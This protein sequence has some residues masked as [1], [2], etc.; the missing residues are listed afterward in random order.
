[1]SVALRLPETG[2]LGVALSGGGDSMALLHMVAAER[3]VAAVTV[4]HGL[5]DVRAEIDLCARACARLGVPHRVLR[6]HWDG[7]GNLQAQARAARQHLI[8]AWAHDRGITHV[9]LGHTADDQ[10]ETVLM[11][12]ARGSG[13][14]GLAAMAPE[15]RAAGVSWLRPL[16]AWRRADLRAWLRA[17]GLD[18]ADDPSN[19]DPGFDRVRARQA[20]QVLSGLGLT[21]ERLI[22]LAD[23]AGAARPVLDKAAQDW[24]QAHV[25]EDRGDLILP[26]GRP[27]LD[28]DS[29]RR[30]LAAAVQWIGGSPYRPRWQALRAVLARDGPGTLAGCLITPGPAGLR[31]SREAARCQGRVPAGQI[32]DGRWRVCGAAGAQVGALGAE[33]LRACPDWRAQGL[34]RASLLASPALWQGDTLI[35][36]PLARPAPGYSAQIVADFRSFLV[37]R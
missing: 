10:A 35:A 16:L 6:W 23:H 37:S 12:L 29:P 1:M 20:M 28:S 26:A 22:R 36:A 34:P 4:N 5:R 32:W 15:T 33:G 30:V 9:A 3:A 24:A 27:A 8:G 19:D 11:R 7:Q 13:I 25:I 14:D 21:H 2:L 17:R 31:L 18:W